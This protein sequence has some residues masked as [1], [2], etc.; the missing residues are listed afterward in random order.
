MN[1]RLPGRQALVAEPNGQPG[2]WLDRLQGA[3]VGPIL[4]AG[5]VHHKPS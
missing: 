5:L 2:Q 3:V 1:A 4:A